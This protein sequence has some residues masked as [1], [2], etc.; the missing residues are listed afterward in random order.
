MRRL[1][2]MAAGGA[3]G[4]VLGARAGRPAYDRIMDGWRSIADSTGLTQTAETMRGAAQDL[5]DAGTQAA[6]DR[7]GSTAQQAAGAMD[8]A[9]SRLRDEQVDVSDSTVW[10]K[11]GS[12]FEEG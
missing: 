6:R 5:G 3:V 8:A 1:L 10:T 4:Y 2:L 11:T 9:A 7:M 12:G